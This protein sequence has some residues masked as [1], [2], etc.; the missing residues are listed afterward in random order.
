MLDNCV[1]GAP[2]SGEMPLSCLVREGDKKASIPEAYAHQ[3][4]KPYGVLSY[5]M[6]TDGNGHEGHQPQVMD[7][8]HIELTSEVMPT[9]LEGE[10]ERF[11]QMTLE[12]VQDAPGNG[13]FKTNR[14]L[15][16]IS[17]L[18]SSGIVQRRARSGSVAVSSHLH[19][20]HDFPTK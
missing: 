20:E 12:E 14:S 11:E 10:V 9:P 7:V 16:W 4:A 6:S 15:T 1:G 17:Y 8:Y 5:H 13:E 19:R 2:N 18:I 3:N